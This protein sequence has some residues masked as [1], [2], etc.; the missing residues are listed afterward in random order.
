[1]LSTLL[2]AEAGSAE[3]AAPA[4]ALAIFGVGHTA[5]PPEQPPFDAHRLN[6]FKITGLITPGAWLVTQAMTVVVQ[7]P[8]LPP[9]RAATACAKSLAAVAEGSVEFT[10]GTTFCEVMPIPSRWPS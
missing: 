9:G 5:L 1:M 3:L 4:A 8:G 2:Y 10:V 6:R 7:R